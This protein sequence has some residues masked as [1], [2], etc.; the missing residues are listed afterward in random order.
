[1]HILHQYHYIH[2]SLIIKHKNKNYK[3][4]SIYYDLNNIW[5]NTHQPKIQNSRLETLTK[6]NFTYLHS[7]QLELRKEQLQP[8]AN[9]ENVT[10]LAPPQV[11]KRLYKAKSTI[12]EF[13]LACFF[14]RACCIGKIFYQISW[15]FSVTFRKCV[16]VFYKMVV[17]KNFMNIFAIIRG[18]IFNWIRNYRPN[19]KLKR[20][21]NKYGDCH[22]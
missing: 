5:K 3:R 14:I 12:S 11:Y 7:N 6:C 10:S 9:P 13:L 21:A 4:N 22:M 2:S 15:I 20:K 19:S 1:M 16:V 18:Q 8:I 17:W